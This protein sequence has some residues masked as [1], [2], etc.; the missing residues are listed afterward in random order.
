M[1]N[2]YKILHTGNGVSAPATN[3]TDYLPQWSGTDNKT[4]KDG[5][6]VPAGGLAGLTA[7]G[8]KEDSS[9]KENTTMDTS[10]TK[11]PTNRLAKEYSDTKLAKSTNITAIND[12]GI[13]DGEIM[14]ANLTSKDIRTSDK[15]IV[16]S[17]GADDTT[18]PTSKAVKDVTDAKLSLS[19]GTMTGDITFAAGKGI[20]LTLPTTDGQCSGNST[21]SFVAGETVALG[22]VV[23]FKSDGKWWLTDSD[24]VVTCKGLI[25]IAL[26]AG[27][28]N[29]AITVALPNS[30]IHVDA[31]AWTAGDTLYVGDAT[32]GTLQNAIPTGADCIIKVAGFAID[33]D[34]IFFNPS[35][36]QQ[37]T[38]A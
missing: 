14:V 13:A 35:P 15:T 19:G 17:L 23:F 11:F 9:N 30:F 5:L 21:A 3:T 10:T 25:G 7:L 37:S 29:D 33:A 18:V 1:A 38:I 8:A 31:W 32:A 6:A 36:D 12:T 2:R 20:K 22:N 16:T 34:T 26:S 27:N 4:L 28:A 24:A